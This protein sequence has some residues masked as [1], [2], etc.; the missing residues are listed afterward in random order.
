MIALG[1]AKWLW[2]RNTTLVMT[3]IQSKHVTD[4][5]WFVYS[6][7]NTNCTDLGATL[8]HLLGFKV[9]LQFKP[10]Y[11]G[12]PSKPQA[13]AVHLLADEGDI[14]PIM[15]KLHNIYS[16][17][18][19]NNQ[20]ADY[21]LGQHL[22]LA[23]MA[24][25]LNNHNL[26]SLLQLKTEQT[27][28]CHQVVMVTTYAIANLDL[29]FSFLGDYGLH[30]WSLCSLLMQVTHPTMDTCTLFQAIDNYSVGKGVVFTML[31]STVAY[32]HN[33]VLGIIPFTCWLLELVYGRNQ[34][35]N[36]DPAFS[37]DMLQE[38]A[39]TLWDQDNNC[40][41][42]KEGNLLDLSLNNLGIY[43]LCK[44]QY[45]DNYHSPGGHNRNRIS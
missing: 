18:C 35:S 26:A 37:P 3:P 38:M 14:L 44:K 41:Q 9:G 20:A 28:F 7:K 15:A 27:S 42:Q 17:G 13:S 1:V 45:G 22:L 31:P 23:P 32:S 2:A 40:V 19:M 29:Q 16:K 39:T 6:T 43:D 33:A 5:C 36:L 21:P 4:L 24:K 30:Y 11:T 10:I 34:A 8:M 12:T 25:G